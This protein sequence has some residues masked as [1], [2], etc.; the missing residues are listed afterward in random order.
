[1]LTENLPEMCVLIAKKEWRVF[2]LIE[3]IPS[4][5]RIFL[6]LLLC[7]SLFEGS[8]PCVQPTSLAMNVTHSKIGSAGYSP[9]STL[10]VRVDA[11]HIVQIYENQVA[12]A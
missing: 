7:L 4:E 2:S 6:P 8:F 10:L 5:C 11:D 1:M 3:S 9:L 12:C